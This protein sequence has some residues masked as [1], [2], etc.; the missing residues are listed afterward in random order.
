[1]KKL[2]VI[3]MIMLIGSTAWAVDTPIKKAT[4]EVTCNV[5]GVQQK[6]KTAAACKALGGTVVVTPAAKKWS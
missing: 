6:V 5:N 4:K 2:V 3:G 1:M